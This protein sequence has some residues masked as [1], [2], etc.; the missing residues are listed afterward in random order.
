MIFSRIF[1]LF[2]VKREYEELKNMHESLRNIAID[3]NKQIEELSRENSKLKMLLDES[4]K[5]KVY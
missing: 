3:Q 2:K 4:S 1:K 5:R